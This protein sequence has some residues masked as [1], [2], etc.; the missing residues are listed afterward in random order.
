MWVGC[1]LSEPRGPGGPR[2]WDAGEQ[3]ETWTEALA[4]TLVGAL[5]VAWAELSVGWAQKLWGFLL[6]AATQCREAA[7]AEIDGAVDSKNCSWQMVRHNVPTA[8]KAEQW[9]AAEDFSAPSL[10]FLRAGGPTFR[11]TACCI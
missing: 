1:D 10:C 3:S 9:G 2:C 11:G 8:E 5:A 4:E 6:L 7:T